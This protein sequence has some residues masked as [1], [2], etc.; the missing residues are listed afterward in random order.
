M[1]T[2]S[3]GVYP[4]AVIASVQKQLKELQEE[5]QDHDDDGGV[6]DSFKLQPAMQIARLDDAVM[7]KLDI[8]PVHARVRELNATR[9]AEMIS[10]HSGAHGSICFVE[11]G[12][13]DD[14]LLEFNEKYFTFPIYRDQTWTFYE[15][16][17]NRKI[18]LSL[19]WNPFSVFSI[20]C[21]T[22]QRIREKKIDGNMKGDGIIQ[23]GIIFFGRDGQPKAA[24]QEETGVDLRIRDII[25]TLNAIRKEG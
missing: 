4:P 19:L 8:D 10:N 24:Y 14:G 7:F 11:T 2:C 25:A 18:G 16:L 23:G 21:E 22:Y 12:V 3:R 17:G 6:P 1:A 9:G 13:D 5:E 15:A 20:M